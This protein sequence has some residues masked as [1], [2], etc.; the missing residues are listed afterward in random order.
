MMG[1]DVY[2]V[3]E[4]L[5]EKI[6]F[7]HFRNAKGDKYKFNETFHDDGAIDMANVMRHYKKCGVDVPIRVDHVP[8]MAGEDNSAP[9]YTALGRLFA[10]GYLKG[11]LDAIE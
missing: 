9:G 1:E 3:I 6:F 4:K 2:D 11:I 5:S 8:N 10:I 7:V